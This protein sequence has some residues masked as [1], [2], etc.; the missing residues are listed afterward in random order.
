MNNE[1]LKKILIDIEDQKIL[2]INEN[3]KKIPMK[4][5]IYIEDLK[6]NSNK[7]AEK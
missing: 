3:L 4:I 2:I 5:L 6:K 7:H 1:D